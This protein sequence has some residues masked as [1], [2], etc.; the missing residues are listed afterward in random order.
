M[1]RRQASAS[2]PGVRA[3]ERRIGER[4]V[5]GGDVRRI[6]DDEVETLRHQRRE[7]AAHA[8]VDGA[9]PESCGI[10]ARHLE[11][12]RRYIRGGYLPPRAFTRQRQRHGPTTG[13]EVGDA[14]VRLTA[15]GECALH[16]QLGLWTRYQHRR[17]DRERQ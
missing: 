10:G 1:T 15:Q 2:V 13:A 11:R 17:G 7:P 16:E 8:E 12:L 9:E 14:S 6:A 3:S 4:R 5:A